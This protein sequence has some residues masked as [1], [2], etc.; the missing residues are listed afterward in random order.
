[1]NRAFTFFATLVACSLAAGLPAAAQTPPLQPRFDFDSAPGQLPKAVVPLRHAM[2]LALDPGA[3]GFSGEASVL[4]RVRQPVPALVLNAHELAATSAVLAGSAGGADRPLTV[5]PGVAPQTWQMVPADGLPIA[6][7]EHRLQLAWTGGVQ[8]TGS[9]L[10]RVPHQAFGKPV[11]M[12]ATQLQAVYARMLFPSFDEPAFR[13]VFEIS[14]R[15]PKG[16]EVFSNMPARA[17]PAADSES[18]VVHRFTATPPMPSYLVAVAVGRFDSLAGAAA[19]VP[20]RI[21]AAPGKG[22]QG[23]YAMGVTQQLLPYFTDYFGVPYA[24]PKLDQVAVPGTRNG[25]MEDWGLISYAE[26]LLLFDPASSDTNTQRRVFSLVA[27]EIAHQWFGNLVT[28]AS[29]EEIWLN[30]AFATWMA[31]KATAHFNPEWQ[32]PLRRRQAIDFAMGR[33]AGPSTR[34]IRS[35]AVPEDRVHDVFDGITYDK[36]GAVLSMLEGWIGADAFRRGLAAYM[37]ERRL[38]NATAG[39]LWHHL[40][41]AA[42]RDVAAVAS[43]WTDQPGFP[44]VVMQSRCDAGKTQLTL[45]QRRFRTDGVASDATVWKVPMVLLH[46]GQTQTLLL[47]QAQQTHELPGCPALPTLLNPG[48]EGF[49]RVAYPAAQQQALSQALVQLPSTAQAALLSDTFALAQAGELPMSAWLT[50]MA[51][52]SQVQDTGRPALYEHARSRFGQLR[53]LMHGSAGAPALDAAA[54]A[55]FGPA[56]EALGWVPRA[57]ESSEDAALRS[58]LIQALARHGD[59][60]V[61]QRAQ[62]L[63]DDDQAGRAALPPGVRAGVL[64]AVGYGGDAARFGQ[65]MARLKAAQREEDRW[66]LASAVGATPHPALARQVLVLSLSD[67]LPGNIAVELPGMVADQPAHGEM[68]Y[69]HVL[70]HWPRLAERAGTMFGAQ[71]WLLPDAA[72]SFS[73]ADDA[74]RLRADQLRLAGPTG[75]SSAA[76]V[77]AAI[78][79][80]AALRNREAERLPAAL[81]ALTQQLAA[82][83]R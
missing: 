10:F 75:A 31:E 2:T 37:A 45:T 12:L 47:Q 60:A 39:D 5:R 32:I 15:A 58:A 83:R 72:S 36:G 43:S 20:L 76:R 22:P 51:G 44:A 30:E 53:T 42:G 66:L 80:R 73:N 54:R 41:K 65:L 34:A 11:A 61:V 35:G 74:V 71:G 82:T 33:D 77:A 50:L 19:G 3:E 57:G 28:A 14:V 63:F 13:T 64:R 8:R 23:A 79:M 17:E 27:H 59:S 69:R 16:Y 48:G 7:G 18:T 52:L 6:A 67:D 1:M 68:A 24:L 9:A 81:T 4:L 40:G 70:Q 78:E 29:W 46:G 56:L 49:Y 38:S 26:S 62:S 25:A 21:L 55:L